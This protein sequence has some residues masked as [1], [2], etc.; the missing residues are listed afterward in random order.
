MIES[1][2]GVAKAEALL[3]AGRPEQAI[4]LL[5]KQIAADPDNH[6]AHLGLAVAFL[7]VGDAEQALAAATSAVELDPDDEAGHILVSVACLRKGKIKLARRAAEEAVS[8]APNDSLAHQTLAEVLVRYPWKRRQAARV[9]SR[10]IELAPHDPYAH[11]GAG[12]VATQRKRGALQRNPA[13]KHY[14]RAL[15]LD[16]TNTDAINNLAVSKLG[17]WRIA[18]AVTG[19]KDVATIDPSNPL[20]TR[21]LNGAVCAAL[22]QL[23]WFAWW[24]AVIAL[25]PGPQMAMVLVIPAAVGYC[26][27]LRRAVGPAVLRYAYG[28]IRRSRAITVWTVALAVAYAALPFVTPAHLLSDG[29]NAELPWLVAVCAILVAL[30]SIPFTRWK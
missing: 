7:A 24:L 6:P 2:T 25:F 3:Q 5:A 9:A 19:F 8:L 20:A 29:R 26:W 27:W 22:I 11:I 28:L 13:Y 10:A 17:E 12:N 1:G 30:V 14:R 21:N 16:P 18:A 15:E 23:T 4:A